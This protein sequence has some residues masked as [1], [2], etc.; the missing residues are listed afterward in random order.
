MEQV[1]INRFFVWT[2]GGHRPSVSHHNHA[3]ALKEAKR[4]AAKNPG[5]RFIVQQFHEKVFVEVEPSPSVIGDTTMETIMQKKTLWAGISGGQVGFFASNPTNLEGV[6][7]VRKFDLDNNN[8]VDEHGA[9][10]L[11]PVSQT[12]Q[13]G[14]Q[15]A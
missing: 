6:T 8:I 3:K 2:K 13:T 14:Q 5:L 7:A 12:S 10:I 11:E 1:A 9:S 4:L 15:T